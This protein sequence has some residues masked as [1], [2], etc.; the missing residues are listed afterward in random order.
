[1]NS[2]E[3]NEMELMLLRAEVANLRI[4]TNHASTIGN[5]T[6]LM[7]DADNEKEVL[8][9]LLYAIPQVVEFD[10]LRFF[11]LDRK[12]TQL[13]ETHFVTP[14]MEQAVEIE[15]GLE[16]PLNMFGGVLADS[17]LRQEV[18]SMENGIDDGDEF[19]IRFDCERYL[20]VPLI[21]RK[22]QKTPVVKRDS[23]RNEDEY[24]NACVQSPDY[25]VLGTFWI[26]TTSVP[27]S[28]IATS[29]SL[30]TSLFHTAGSVIGELRMVERIV[31]N[32]DRIEKD[33]R[34]AR[35]VQMGLLPRE[36]PQNDHIQVAAR[37]ITEDQVGGDYY[38]A[39]E[40]SE[41]IYAITVA[42][43][44][45]HGTPSALIMAMTKILLKTFAKQGVLPS[46]TLELVNNAIVNNTKTNKFIT[47]FYAILDT[48]E[49][50]LHYT[51]AGHCPQLLLNKDTASST[52]LLSDGLFV[53][54]FPVFALD[55]HTVEYTPGVNRLVLYTDGLTES[56]NQEETMYGLKRL[57]NSSLSTIELTLEDTLNKILENQKRFIHN[58]PKDDDLTLMV[59]DF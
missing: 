19:S 48:N 8:S 36:L 27:E 28:Q 12:K 1:L 46:E 4:E 59:I 26:N 13:V 23:Y 33:L 39:F 56:T 2:N 14:E 54:M 58:H 18:S 20:V 45:G 57:E 30:I 6:D 10:A 37:Y 11:S 38:D 49:Q 31:E 51:S 21:T 5:F 35:D 29:I 40:I 22:L 15:D 41:G 42:D 32:N 16:V 44:S 53:G 24:I 3:S 47:I 52:E 50:K 43:A 17:V 55:T 7:Y 25:P 9:I 34:A